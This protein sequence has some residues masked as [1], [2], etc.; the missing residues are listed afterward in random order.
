MWEE[1]WSRWKGDQKG[2][3]GPSLGVPPPTYPVLV[4]EGRRK[5]F[6]SEGEGSE[7]TAEAGSR[8]HH[9]PHPVQRS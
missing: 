5:P 8:D 6:A 3:H 4:W 7:D 1:V 2:F 9:L